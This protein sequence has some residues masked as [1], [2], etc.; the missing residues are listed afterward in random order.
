MEDPFTR[1][2]VVLLELMVGTDGGVQVLDV[3][4]LFADVFLQP[5]VPVTVTR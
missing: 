4:V 2:F 3:T 5:F 1:M